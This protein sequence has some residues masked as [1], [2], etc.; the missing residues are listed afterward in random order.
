MGHRA[1]WS[2]AQLE[3]GKKRAPTT[4]SI[5]QVGI[6][7]PSLFSGGLVLVLVLPGSFPLHLLLSASSAPCCT[8]FYSLTFP[9]P[10]SLA[11]CHC[12]PLALAHTIRPPRSTLPILSTGLNSEVCVRACCHLT[13]S[14]V[15]RWTS[16]APGR[17]SCF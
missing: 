3:V 13:S 17:I 2:V 7:A 9:P 15:P 6:L 14:L 12:P 16:L 4:P 1:W 11:P 5:P 10:T 8:C